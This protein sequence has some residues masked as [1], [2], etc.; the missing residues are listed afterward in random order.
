MDPED[1]MLLAEALEV[2]YGP[3][4]L[5]LL[6]ELV[7]FELPY[8]EYSGKVDYMKMAKTLLLN[9]KLGRNKD[10]L[11][12]IVSSLESRND[13]AIASTDWEQ[14]SYHYGMKPRIQSFLKAIGGGST[15]TEIA[16]RANNPFT[17]KAELREVLS[18]ATTPVTVVDNYIGIATLDCVRVVSHPLR[19][20][21]GVREQAIEKG[22]DRALKEFR[23]EGREIEVRCH[24]K[25]HDRYIILNGRCWLVGSSLKDAGKKMFSMIEATDTRDTI[26]KDVEQ[27]WQEAIEYQP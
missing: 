23:A 8:S 18:T 5:T 14:R 21:T 22:F 20:L 13:R 17:A 2:Y 15:P 19:I 16:V 7:D 9:P 27:K 25:L 12:A 6:A 26:I 24:P 1:I 11:A 4:D 3:D 10:F